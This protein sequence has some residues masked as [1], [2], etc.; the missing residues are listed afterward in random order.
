M[1]MTEAQFTDIRRTD[2]FSGEL[3]QTKKRLCFDQMAAI[4]NRIS[5]HAALAALSF[6]IFLLSCIGNIVRTMVPSPIVMQ[7]ER[8]DFSRVV[9]PGGRTTEVSVLFATTRA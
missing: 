6:G 5:P 4:L 8:L 7:D 3:S 1:L 9:L 2:R